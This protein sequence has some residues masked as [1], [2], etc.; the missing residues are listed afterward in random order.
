MAKSPSLT[1]SHI[2]NSNEKCDLYSNYDNKITLF[3]HRETPKLD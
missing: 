1:R 2:S 3:P